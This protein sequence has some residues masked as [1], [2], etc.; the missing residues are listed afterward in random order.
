M[1]K[2]LDEDGDNMLSFSEF[3]KIIETQNQQNL[4]EKEEY[5]AVFKIC[6][7]DGSGFISA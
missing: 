4:E 7:Y 2:D 1:L 5:M 6:D 3:V